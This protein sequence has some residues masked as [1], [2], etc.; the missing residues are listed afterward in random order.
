MTRYEHL[1]STHVLKEDSH[2]KGIITKLQRLWSELEHYEPGPVP[3]SSVE[4]TPSFVSAMPRSIFLSLSV[5]TSS[6]E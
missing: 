5:S 1:V 4:V 6:D 3:P 2:Q